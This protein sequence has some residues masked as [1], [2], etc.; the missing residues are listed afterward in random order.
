[1]KSQKHLV[2]KMSKVVLL[3]PNTKDWLGPVR[4]EIFRRTLTD[5][6]YQTTVHPIGRTRRVNPAWFDGASLV[7]N[8][9]LKADQEQIRSIALASPEKS[10]IHVNHS[11]TPQIER[12]PKQSNRMTASLFSARDINNIWYGTVDIH[13][14]KLARSLGIERCIHFPGS[15]HLLPP[16]QYKAPGETV[17]FVMGGRCDAIKNI[18]NQL[19][20]ISLSG[21]KSEL[22]LAM[23]P[24]AKVLNLLKLLRIP[25]YVHGYLYHPKW[26][27][28]LSQCDIC[29]SAS[30]T[31][32]FCFVAAEAM[33]V[34]LPTIIS[35][36]IPFGE[37][38]RVDPNDP[39]DIADKINEAVANHCSIAERS[40]I[41]G[42]EVIADRNARYVAAVEHV[43]TTHRQRGPIEQISDRSQFGTVLNS[44]G[45]NGVGV[46]VGVS[47]GNNAKQILSRWSGG[48]LY[49]VDPYKKWPSGEYV[50]PLNDQDYGEI[51]AQCRNTLAPWSD[52]CVHVFQP[53]QSAVEQFEDQSLDFVYLDGNHHEPQI[54]QDLAAWFP[55]VRR[56][57]IFAGHD[58]YTKD[59]GDYRCQVES[60]VNRFATANNLRVHVTSCTSWWI[61]KP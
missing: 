49:L 43:L 51:L 52:R 3:V 28:L 41:V 46:E 27:A 31:E 56:G 40:T 45:L 16:R 50:D 23:R 22:H 8:H 48:T 29:L 9:T 20:A 53:S 60:A 1:M 57:G 7:V 24:E 18:F 39:Q 44:L 12:C 42:R 38:L 35:P 36:T 15:G 25:Y 37:S 58:Y 32:S 54:S 4:A 17:K 61:R 14:E 2:E 5:A 47:R 10:F 34:G 55:K 26:I 30:L 59:T 19:M 33:Q 13:A 21:I 6:G 11:A